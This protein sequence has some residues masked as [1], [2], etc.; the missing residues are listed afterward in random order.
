MESANETTSNRVKNMLATRE[1][2]ATEL[3]CLNDTARRYS[4]LQVKNSS[5]IQFDECILSKR[6]QD[7]CRRCELRKRDEA[8]LEF[9]DNKALDC[10]LSEVY[11]YFKSS[12]ARSI[13]DDIKAKAL[14]LDRPVN[15]VRVRQSLDDVEEVLLSSE[16]SDEEY[17]PPSG[18]LPLRRDPRRPVNNDGFL[19]PL[20]R[21]EQLEHNEAVDAVQALGLQQ[22]FDHYARLASKEERLHFRR[23]LLAQQRQDNKTSSK[24]QKRKHPLL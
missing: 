16:S 7:E 21:S 9:Y 1:Q 14:V 18:T 11:D 8:F 22:R 4:E 17:I 12:H 6:K 5:I 3:D 20:S 23:Q 2:I 13:V 19:R 24:K 15:Q 10:S